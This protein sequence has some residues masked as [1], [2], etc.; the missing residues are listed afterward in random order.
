[1][2]WRLTNWRIII[3]KLLLLLNLLAGKGERKGMG[4]EGNR[5]GREAKRGEAASYLSL[6]IYAIGL[7]VM[8]V[9]VRGAG[10]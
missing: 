8:F 4:R 6:A 2:L 10:L 1:M 5:K 3:I 9:N 7:R